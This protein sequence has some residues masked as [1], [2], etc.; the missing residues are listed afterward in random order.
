M[1]CLKSKIFQDLFW[2]CLVS[3]SCSRV[4]CPLCILLLVLVAF[5]GRCHYAWVFTDFSD[6]GCDSWPLRR[7][8]LKGPSLHS[9]RFLFF[10]QQTTDYL[11]LPSTERYF[12]TSKNLSELPHDGIFIPTPVLKA[13]FCLACLWSTEIVLMFNILKKKTERWRKNIHLAQR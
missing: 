7:V 12:Y 13:N 8:C 9:A 10:L 5:Q 11:F 4:W 3:L 6:N 1:L 2:K